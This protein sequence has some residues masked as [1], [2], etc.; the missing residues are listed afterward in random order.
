MEHDSLFDE[1]YRD[2][3]TE[4]EI[5]E[6]VLELRNHKWFQEISAEEGWSE[7]GNTVPGKGGRKRKVVDY[8]KIGESKN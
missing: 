5:A 7:A 2:K 4:S 6:S 1:D 8:S 3:M